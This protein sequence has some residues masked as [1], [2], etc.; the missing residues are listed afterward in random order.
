MRRKR[1]SQGE[2]ARSSARLAEL[3]SHNTFAQE[4]L[5]AGWVFKVSKGRSG[6]CYCTRKVITIP[7]HALLSPRHG[8]DEY[9]LAHEIAHAK[10]GKAAAHGPEFMDWLKYLCEPEFL[11]YEL[12]YKPRNAKAA[13]IEGK[14]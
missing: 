10:A 14:S 2:L 1:R 7:V 13:G 12:G 6:Y 11:H 3:V 8:Y 9:Y 4:L 5:E